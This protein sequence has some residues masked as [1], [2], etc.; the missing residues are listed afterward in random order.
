MLRTFA[1]V[2]L[3]TSLVAG[4]ALAAEPTSGAGSPPPAATATGKTIAAPTHSAKPGKFAQHTRKQHARKHSARVKHR[5]IKTV[6][7][8]KG[9]KT[10]K[11]HVAKSTKPAK[12]ATNNRPAGVKTAR[13]PAAHSGTN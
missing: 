3:A 9:G 2:L 12:T 13:L 1:A 6:H 8:V 5:S 11:G 7:H 4:T 10:H